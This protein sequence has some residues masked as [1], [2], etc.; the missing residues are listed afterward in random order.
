MEIE[1]THG[2]AS[3][4]TLTPEARQ[5]TTHGRRS[6]AERWVP[7]PCVFS[8]TTIRN[9]ANKEIERATAA[10]RCFAQDPKRHTHQEE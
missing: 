5:S 10:K 7:V 4:A 9:R 1:G 8:L 6:F 2:L 3:G